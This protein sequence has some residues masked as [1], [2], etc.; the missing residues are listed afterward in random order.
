MAVDS[1]ADDD[2]IVDDNTQHQDKRQ[3]RQGADID[4]GH[5]KYPQGAHYSD[6]NA[7]RDPHGYLESKK[8]CENKHDQDQTR[9]GILGQGVD[10]PTQ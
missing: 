7:G 5:R 4:A 2:G 1:L 8:Q 6:G 10:S 9:P 3:H